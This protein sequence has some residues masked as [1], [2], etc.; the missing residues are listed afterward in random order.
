MRFDFDSLRNF[1]MGCPASIPVK[2]LRLHLFD[3]YRYAEDY[4]NIYK[5]ITDL[6]G[7]IE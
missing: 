5:L 3:M 6:G 4:D 1:I 2:K 7:V